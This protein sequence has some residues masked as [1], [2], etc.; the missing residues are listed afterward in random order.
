M[1]NIFYGHYSMPEE[2]IEE[3]WKNCVFVFDT[4]VL[5][6]MFRLSPKSAERLLSIMERQKKRVWLP[7]QIAE[8]YHSN[9]NSVIAKQAKQCADLKK[10]LL[11]L[12]GALK[13]KRCQSFL[14][15]LDPKITEALS[16]LENHL[17]TTETQITQSLHHNEI[18]DC[19]AKIF[20]QKIG[21][22]TSIDEYNRRCNDAKGRYQDKIPPGFCDQKEKK[23]P[24]CYG[25]YQIW[26]DLIEYANTHQRDILLVS[27]D[28]KEDWICKVSGQYVGPLP[29]L[30]QEFREK[31]NGRAY[32]SY[33]LDKFIEEYSSRFEKTKE[34]PE[35]EALIQEIRDRDD[36]SEF[37]SADSVI[38]GETCIEYNFNTEAIDFNDLSDSGTLTD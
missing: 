24:E 8:E 33:T 30:R 4:N 34:S 14:S 38:S 21:S 10:D 32:Y 25:D 19:I 16:D 13:N 12:T 29:A 35:N 28:T 11:K 6:D 37:N 7:Y 9:L 3:F 15:D 23:E 18:K 36:A 17:E 22:K 5:L 20:D 1:R 2:Q 27:G 31:T 26:C